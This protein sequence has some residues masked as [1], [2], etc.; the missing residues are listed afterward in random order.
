MSG[1]NMLEAF[2]GPA[3]SQKKNTPQMSL[4]RLLEQFHSF[5]LCSLEGSH[6]SPYI[7]I[8]HIC[9]YIYVNLDIYV[10]IYRYLGNLY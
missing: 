3:E 1:Q 10:Y 8:N 9:I 4:R 5:R 2:R 6:I 7:N